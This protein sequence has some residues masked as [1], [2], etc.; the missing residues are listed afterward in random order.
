MYESEKW[1]WCRSVVSDSSQP[2]GLQ[3]T[4]LLCPWDFPGKSTGVDCHCLL[5][6]TPLAQSNSAL[7]ISCCSFIL[8]HA[9][10][11]AVLSLAHYPQWGLHCEVNTKCAPS[12]SRS[13]HDIQTYCGTSEGIWKKGEVTVLWDLPFQ[14]WGPLGINTYTVVKT[15]GFGSGNVWIWVPA[16]PSWARKS[17][18]S[19]VHSGCVS[20]AA[21][22]HPVTTVG[23][24]DWFL[25]FIYLFNWKIITLQRGDGFCHTSPWIAAGIRVSPPSWTPS[26]LSPHPVPLGCPR[27]LALDALL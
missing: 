23:L 12:S 19:G 16:L 2:H 6:L 20:E 18:A 17:L 13:L 21:V 14:F 24:V 25:K 8:F 4:R 1:K 11:L 3:P 26:L 5:R 9:S 22:G 27:E 7:Y 10:L 15:A